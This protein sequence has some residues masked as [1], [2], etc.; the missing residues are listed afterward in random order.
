MSL[1]DLYDPA[2]TIQPQTSGSIGDLYG[3]KNAPGKTAAVNSLYIGLPMQSKLPPGLKAGLSAFGQGL[4]Y[5]AKAAS[6]SGAR[7]PGAGLTALAH[8]PSESQYQADLRQNEHTM[9]DEAQPAF[10]R[11]L[12]QRIPEGVKHFAAATL[13]D[14]LTYIGGSGLLEQGV[15][16][17]A[18]EVASLVARGASKTKIGRS[19]YDAF[20]HRGE[21]VRGIYGALPAQ[22]AQNVINKLEIEARKAA[23][24]GD[25]SAPRATLDALANA[26]GVN[27][28][29]FNTGP[30]AGLDAQQALS[31]LPHVRAY[32]GPER[33][34]IPGRLGEL[35]SDVAGAQKAVVNATN[36][37]FFMLPARH[38][39]NITALAAARDPLGALQ[40]M[41]LKAR[42]VTKAG[43]EANDAMIQEARDAGITAYAPERDLPGVTGET[44]ANIS[45]RVPLVGKPLAAAIG[46]AGELL[47]KEYKWSQKT[48]WSYDDLM[49]AVLTKRKTE[50]LVRQGLSPEDAV[51]SASHEVNRAL[52]DYGA[53]SPAVS[54][55]YNYGIAPFLT[56]RS[57]IPGAVARTALQHPER[58]AIADRLTGGTATGGTSKTGVQRSYLPEADIGRAISDPD[59][60]LRSTLSWPYKDV[61]SIMNAPPPVKSAMLG[62]T[63]SKKNTERRYFTYGE[64]VL[65]LKRKDKG[66]PGMLPT[67]LITV[68]GNEVLSPFKD[69]ESFLQYMLQSTLGQRI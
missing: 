36:I 40:S 30:L 35:A 11:P 28:K 69:K 29:R 64:P 56:F 12:L 34:A 58:L 21:A 10:L 6:A 13:L 3:K 47:N 61:L 15:R 14:P 1:G 60:Y 2:P 54:E 51:A 44:A 16:H 23:N 39:S 4:E 24:A 32:L 52:V 48:L 41:A 63:G 9:F 59:A 5:L 38:M 53:R 55:A 37:P 45:K 33:E 65:D 50:A 20:T 22:K 8:P 17:A 26:K 57:G 68:P 43:R 66:F 42:G 19:T 27:L 67:Q 46:K 7:G 18:P 31:A 62:L 25:R 49:R